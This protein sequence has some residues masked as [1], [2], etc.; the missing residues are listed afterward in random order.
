M[1]SRRAV[2]GRRL[3]HIA[4]RS[5]RA[6]AY[7]RAVFDTG[8]AA[9]AQTVVLSL[10]AAYVGIYLVDCRRTH[11]ARE[12]LTDEYRALEESGLV[13]PIE[14]REASAAGAVR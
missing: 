8:I 13:A 11:L 2:R 7:T 1:R 10:A 6:S 12:R 5:L 3:R 14:P 4:L 9:V